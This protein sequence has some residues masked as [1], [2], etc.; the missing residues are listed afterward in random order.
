MQQS[1]YQIDS[2]RHSK[3]KTGGLGLLIVKSIMMLHEGEAYAYNT[4]QGIVFGLSLG[5]NIV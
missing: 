2:S 3:A 1:L 5:L 4:Q